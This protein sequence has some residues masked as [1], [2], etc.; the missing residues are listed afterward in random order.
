MDNWLKKRRRKEKERKEKKRKK[1]KEEQTVV[2]PYRG[3]L[4]SNK[5]KQTIGTYNSLDESLNYAKR[6]ESVPKGH[7][8]YDSIYMPFQNDKMT[9]LENK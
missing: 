2:N 5:K 6:E 3:I 1:K 8:L 4:L 7:I 9:E